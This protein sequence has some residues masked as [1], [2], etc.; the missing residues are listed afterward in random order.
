V[1]FTHNLEHQHEHVC[2]TSD[3]HIDSHE[4][5]CD[6]FHFKINHN[7]ISFET[8]FETIGHLISG[9][10][11]VSYLI[12]EKQNYLLYKLTRAPPYSLL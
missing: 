3:L 8:S 10:L 1:Q 4:Y 11:I 9:E 12:S 6:V 5:D 2:L 7:T